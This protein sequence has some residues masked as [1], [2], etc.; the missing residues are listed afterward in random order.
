MEHKDKW[1]GD[2][3]GPTLMAGAASWI[4]IAVLLVVF[5]L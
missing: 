1:L 4:L 2:C 3:L 5:L